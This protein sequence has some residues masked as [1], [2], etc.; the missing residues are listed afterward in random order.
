MT[1]PRVPLC[2]AV[3]AS[4]SNLG[5]GYDVLGLAL[6]RR[7]T[8]RWSPSSEPLRTELG[9]TLSGL[10][11]QRDLVR[12]TL[13]DVLGVGAGELTGVLEIES[14]IPIARGLGSSAVARIAG[15][16]LAGAMSSSVT[17][18]SEIPGPAQISDTDRHALLER[19]SRSEGHPDNAVPSVV[20]GFVA[21][22]LDDEGLRWT[23]LPFSPSV[24]MAFAA[25]GVE[26][27]TDDA[28]RALPE[29]LTHREAVANGARLA[30]LLAGVARADGDLIRWG[31]KDR[32][33]TPWRWPLVPRADEASAAA[34]GEGAW[35][36]T[37]SGSGSGLIAFCPRDCAEGVAEAMRQVFASVDGTEPACGFPVR[38]SVVGA[39]VQLSPLPDP[40]G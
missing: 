19:V 36:V 37:L 31:L 33:H 4:T 38:R 17:V 2:L 34:L 29:Q 12:A 15:H 26:V 1:G 10:D 11:P 5:P 8:V 23:P 3:P 32:L 14:E 7:L 35:G 13:L 22:S 25:P 24:G 21:G 16:V 39:A 40:A 9:G 28:R 18:S 30:H 27:R 20:G 6:D